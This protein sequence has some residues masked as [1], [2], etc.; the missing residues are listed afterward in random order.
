MTNAFFCKNVIVDFT[1]LWEM[2]RAILLASFS[3]SVTKIAKFLGVGSH[4]VVTGL[5]TL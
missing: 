5:P 3:K 4:S 2:F 1:S